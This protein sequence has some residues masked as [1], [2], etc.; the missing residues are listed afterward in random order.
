MAS[1]LDDCI[2]LT[3]GRLRRLHAW[4]KSQQ[5]EPRDIA[6]AQMEFISLELKTLAAMI[7]RDMRHAN[8]QKSDTEE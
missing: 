1:G 6:I 3:V 5:E 8:L 7:D 2:D 4:A